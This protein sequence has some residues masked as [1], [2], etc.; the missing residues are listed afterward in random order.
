M[1][2]KEFRAAVVARPGWT[3]AKR[4]AA[5]GVVVAGGDKCAD[6]RHSCGKGDYHRDCFAEVNDEGYVEF[7]E[8]IGGDRLRLG[9]ANPMNPISARVHPECAR[10]LGE[11]LM[12]ITED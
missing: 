5:S 1:K 8:A 10:S 9:V 6:R 2:L 4:G 3:C 12:R 7:G 11:W